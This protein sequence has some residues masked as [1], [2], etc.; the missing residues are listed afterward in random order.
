MS[1]PRYSPA[2]NVPVKGP[3]GS[4]LA[5]NR[6]VK[7]TA[8]KDANGEYTAGY[9]QAADRAFG[10]TEQGTSDPAVV[11][12]SAQIARTNVV[13]PGAIARVEAGAAFSA[14]A[15]VQSDSTGRAIT[16]VTGGAGGLVKGKALEAASG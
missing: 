13:R 6:F 4:T 15:S 10:V 16:A 1:G 11:G 7:I 3:S 2:Q 14:L 9:A 8:G 12:T 5:P